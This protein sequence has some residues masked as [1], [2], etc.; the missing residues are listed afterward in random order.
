MAEGKPDLDRS[1][2]P[3]LE[4]LARPK[5]AVAAFVPSSAIA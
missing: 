2:A 3:S 5:V 1:F 4:P